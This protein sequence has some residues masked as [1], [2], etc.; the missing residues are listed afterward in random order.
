MNRKQH[1]N[2]FFKF[3]KEKD[4]RNIPLPILFKY[5]NDLITENDI[6]QLLHVVDPKTRA[7]TYNV[8]TDNKHKFLSIMNFGLISP[9]ST[10]AMTWDNIIFID[11]N[12]N[13]S[14][15]DL[16]P[17]DFEKVDNMPHKIY[18]N[19]YLNSIQNKY[20]YTAVK[21]E[22]NLLI[23]FVRCNDKKIH[24][25]YR[26]LTYINYEGPVHINLKGI[27]D[28]NFIAKSSMQK[29]IQNNTANFLKKKINIIKQI[30]HHN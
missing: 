24:H 30:Y 27:P 21:F 12:G 11:F 17:L 8:I 13:V 28:P 4:N 3:L 25:C 7:K 10:L 1:I 15:S 22:N 29:Q 5:Y 16:I 2:N 18:M 6:H 23:G 19:A 9:I 14:T 26:D 20:T